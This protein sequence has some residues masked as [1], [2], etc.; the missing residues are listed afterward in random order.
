MQQAESVRENEIYQILCNYEIQ[1]DQ[2]ILTRKPDLE[3]INYIYPTP[4]LG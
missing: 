3:F 1:T 2:L 4:P